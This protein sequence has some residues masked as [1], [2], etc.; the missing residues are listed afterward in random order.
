MVVLFKILFQKI[1]LLKC[2]WGSDLTPGLA[3]ERKKLLNSLKEMA[4]TV[5]R[6]YFRYLIVQPF[7]HLHAFSD[8]SKRAYATVIYLYNGESSVLVLSKTKVA[9]IQ[10]V[11]IPRLELLS[12]LLLAE[13]VE[14]VLESLRAWLTICNIIFWSDSLDALH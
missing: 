8:A 12:C 14:I 7:F 10:P 13:S 5:P 2:E 3:S 11:S 9:Q 1:P 6:F 4:F